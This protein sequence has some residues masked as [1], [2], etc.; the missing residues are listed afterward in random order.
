MTKPSRK[1][2][3][4][5]QAFAGSSVELAHRF[6]ERERA[7]SER[8]QRR[9]RAA[10]DDHIG[11]I[12]AD[13]TQ[14]FADRDRAAGATVRVRRARAAEAKFDRDVGVRGAAEDLKRER[15]V[16]AART[17]FQ[18]M[19]VLGFGVRDAAERGAETHADAMLRLFARP[20]DAGVVERELGRGDGKLRVAIEPFQPMRRKKF[21]RNPDRNLRRA[22]RVED[23]AVETSSTRR[24]PLFS[25]RKP[26]QNSS[27]PMPIAGDRAE[28]GDDGASFF[29]RHIIDSLGARFQMRLHARRV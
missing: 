10:G 4:G 24:T 20:F 12:I 9:F 5:R 6:D 8:T 14:R 22:M 27:R 15:L 21:F 23:R 18:E 17:F 25:A 2:S 26:F 13:I 16:H 1:R 19:R 11:E 7:E 28:A 3:N 29:R